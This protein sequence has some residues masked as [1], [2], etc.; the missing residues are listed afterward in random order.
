M[1]DE[2]AGLARKASHGDGAQGG[3]PVVG[4]PDG[5]ARTASDVAGPTVDVGGLLKRC[6]RCE[7]EWIARIFTRPKRCPN[8]GSWRWDNPEKARAYGA[9]H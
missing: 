9:K 1:T 4:Y 2:S 8:C 7:H 3:A 5:D 6:L